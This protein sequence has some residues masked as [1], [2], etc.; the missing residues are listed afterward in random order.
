MADRKFKYGVYMK[1]S[2]KLVVLE[3]GDTCKF[4]LLDGRKKLGLRII[5]K[6]V[7]VVLAYAG[8][9]GETIGWGP[10]NYLNKCEYLGEL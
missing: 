8:W 4:C 3:K 7:T 1:P 10:T 2:G 5:K 9:H 6:K